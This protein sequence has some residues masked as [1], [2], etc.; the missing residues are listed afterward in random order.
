MNDDV[1]IIFER[2][3][4][5]IEIKEFTSSNTITNKNRIT[6]NYNIVPIRW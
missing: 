3:A 6:N 5:V 2:K 1:S 4:A